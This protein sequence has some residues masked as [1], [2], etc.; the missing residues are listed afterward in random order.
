MSILIKTIR[1][2]LLAPLVSILLFEE[3][4]WKPL[5]LLFAKL[6]KLPMWAGLERMI[7]HLPPGAALLA[8]GVPVASLIPVKLLALYLFAQGH[9]V[10]GLM[11]LIAAKVLGTAVAARLFELTKP[12]LMRMH[13][14]A[15]VYVPFKHWKDHLLA[16]VRQ[17][18]VWRELRKIKSRIKNIWS[19]NTDP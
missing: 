14:F 18:A 8:F 3:W 11:L 9:A 10:S 16:Q 19:G 17:S 2:V 12:A 7:T 4:G 13:W 6:A 5:A 1:R 15:R